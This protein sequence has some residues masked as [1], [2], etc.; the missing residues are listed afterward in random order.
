MTMHV[1][2]R[3]SLAVV[4]GFTAG[5]L[6]TAVQMLLWWLSATPVLE[7]LL[8]DARLTAAIALGQAVLAS[9]PTWRWDILL[10]ATLTHFTLSIIYAAIAMPY[11]RRLSVRLAIV[12]GALYGLMLYGINLH[13]LTE[14]M[15]WFS[16]SRGWVTLLT[17]VIFG[18]TLAGV[19]RLLS[20][21]GRGARNSPARH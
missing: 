6:A 20:S 10:V 5:T 3:L 8:R 4:S 14:F 2:S 19:G 11:V 1:E 17:H 12:T 13:A 18:I 16:V 9:E 21:T 7:T 15:P